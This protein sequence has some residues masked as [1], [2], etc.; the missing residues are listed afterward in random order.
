MCAV[1][2]GGGVLSPLQMR[3]TTIQ[4]LSTALVTHWPPGARGGPVW[5][6][7]E[8][9]RPSVAWGHFKWRCVGEVKGRDNPNASEVFTREAMKK[10]SRL[11]GDI[12]IIRGKIL[13]LESA[14]K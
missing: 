2:E 5:A 13:A 11:V 10:C 6:A 1:S 9:L 7:R 8:L 14:A 3:Q 4:A 12:G